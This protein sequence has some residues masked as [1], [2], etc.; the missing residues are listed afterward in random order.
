VR[1][2][3][4]IQELG[5]AL[6]VRRR[7]DDRV[8]EVGLGG[9]PFAWVDLRHPSRNWFTPT[10]AYAVEVALPALRTGRGLALDLAAA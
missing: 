8:A 10:H 7:I 3:R 9:Q 1:F 4:R 6:V 2:L 5:K